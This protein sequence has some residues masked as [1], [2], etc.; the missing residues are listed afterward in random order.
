MAETITL[1]FLADQQR[2]ILDELALMRDDIRV[3][4][5]IVLRHEE[6]LIR[7]LEQMTAMVAQNARI[8][9]RLRTLD[10][11]VSRLEEQEH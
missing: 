4:T 7:V 9:D 1:E 3:L 6:T 5:A 10:E 8:V 2:R 11:R